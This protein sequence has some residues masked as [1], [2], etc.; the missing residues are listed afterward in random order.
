VSSCKQHGDIKAGGSEKEK[1]RKRTN[2]GSLLIVYDKAKATLVSFFCC[3]ARLS[4][5]KSLFPCLSVS[6]FFRV[7]TRAPLGSTGSSKETQDKLVYLL[8]LF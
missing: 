2:I 4:P 6:V 8:G 5:E 3:R 1:R 7:F